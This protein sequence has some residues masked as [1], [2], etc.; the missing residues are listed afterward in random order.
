MLH[1]KFQGHPPSVPREKIFYG[2]YHVGMA[3]M[4]VMCPEP[5]EQ[6]LFP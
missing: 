5:F 3:A 6:F 2:F 4:L 1:I